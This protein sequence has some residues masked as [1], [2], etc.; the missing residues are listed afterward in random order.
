LAGCGGG[1]G[2]GGSTTT[3]TTDTTAPIITLTGENPMTV[4]VGSTFT[5][6]GATIADNVDAGLV[7]TIDGT[8][9]T[10]TLGDYTLTYNTTDSAGNI[11]TTVTRTVTIVSAPF[12][13]D[14]VIVEQYTGG[15]SGFEIYHATIIQPT[16]GDFNC[17]GNLDVI[18][19]YPGIENTN[20]SSGPHTPVNIKIYVGDG[21]GGFVDG[22]TT[23]IS[24][25]VTQGEFIRK[26]VVADFNGDGCDDAFLADHGIESGDN[27]FWGAPD[28]LL[29]SNGGGQLTDESAN[30]L[31]T[32][33]HFTNSDTDHYTHGA[34]TGDFD[35]DNDIDIL[36]STTTGPGSVILVNDS[37][38]GFTEY[39]QMAR[40]NAGGLWTPYTNTSGLWATF[41][42]AD[43]KDGLDYAVASNSVPDHAA[44][45]N[46]GVGNYQT[47]T[48]VAL[49]P[50]DLQGPQELIL[51]ADVN[52]DGWDDL[53]SGNTSISFDNHTIQIYI[54]NADGTGTFVEDTA[55]RLNIDWTG[56]NEPGFN[57]PDLNNDGTKDLAFEVGDAATGV[58]K[59]YLNVNGVF[60]EIDH[61][62]AEKLGNFVM[63]D[64]DKDGDIDIF[65]TSQPTGPSIVYIEAAKLITQ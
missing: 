7:A 10:S 1:G 22:T 43:H 56:N 12:F 34:A 8:V 17:D 38:G 23:V 65:G 16:A 41:V 4:E 11:A 62:I 64:F 5:D 63:A 15:E 14:P 51:T 19:A 18:V 49:P 27:Q 40:R 36:V 3:G 31:L 50:R 35:G 57:M 29:L 37:V 30:V 13:R 39:N 58:F 21:V 61:G 9:D 24:G 28:A 48:R 55:A 42:N 32:T 44:Y 25:T 60:T 6:P 54:N 47:L 2:N 33:L 20:N 45:L 26:I 59:T 46:D 52:S 53:V